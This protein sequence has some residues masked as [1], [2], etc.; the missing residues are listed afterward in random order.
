[1]HGAIPEFVTPNIF[2]FHTLVSLAKDT[3]ELERLANMS[4]RDFLGPRDLKAEDAI[5]KPRL[6][7][8]D[9]FEELF[10][11]QPDRWSEYRGFFEQVSDAL[12]H[13]RMLRSL[14]VMRAEPLARAPSRNDYNFDGASRARKH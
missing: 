12:N 4:L 5:R 2:M 9:H 10:T 7:I 13:D 8:F 6:L 14:F 1:M 3:H 11:V